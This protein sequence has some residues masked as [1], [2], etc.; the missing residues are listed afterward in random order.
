MW[1]V[2][3]EWNYNG[4]YNGMSPGAARDRVRDVVNLI[5]ETDATRPVATI[6]GEMPDPLVIRSLPNVD[7]WGLN[8]Y[9]GI[10]FGDLFSVWQQ[11]S[12]RPMF[13]SEYGADAYNSNEMSEDQASQAEATTVLTNQINAN[14]TLKGGVCSGGAIFEFADEWH[15]DQ[16]GD[17]NTHDTSGKAL[18]EDPILIRHSMKNGGD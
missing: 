4:L 13:L 16:S 5:K 1:V 8:V 3:N 14:S 11:R 2:G 9:R 17:P 18:E 12:R 15:K 6:Y 7:V 10:D